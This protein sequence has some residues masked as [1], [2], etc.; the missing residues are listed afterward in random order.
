MS[1]TYFLGIPAAPNNPSNDQPKMLANTNSINNIIGVDHFTFSGINPGKHTV[2]HTPIPQTVSPGTGTLEWAYYTKQ[3]TSGAV[4]TFWQRPN[5]APGGADIQM[6]TNVTPTATANGYTFIPGGLIIQWGFINSTAS[7]FTDLKFITANVNFPNN[8]FSVF[9]QPYGSGTVP[10]SQATIDI[11]KSTVSTTGF[12]WAFITNST[13]Y[14]GFYWW[15][16]G[17]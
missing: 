9:T 17:N 2:I 16:I 12:Q 4:E 7:S 1:F 3:L 15:A 13:E 6:S 11:R 8:C 5:I 14:T 10:G